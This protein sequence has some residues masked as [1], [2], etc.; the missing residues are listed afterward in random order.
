[1]PS[2][3][4]PTGHT[5]LWIFL[6]VFLLG[7]GGLI[8]SG[9]RSTVVHASR[10]SPTLL[11]KAALPATIPQKLEL[12]NTRGLLALNPVAV[13]VIDSL[14][15]NPA[16]RSGI[17]KITGTNFG[18]QETSQLLIDGKSSPF[19]ARWSDTL[20][21]AHVPEN[22]AIGN[23]TVSITTAVGTGS[24]TVAITTR[25]AD[26]RIRW[27]AEAA[28]DYISQRPAVA[29]PGVPGAGTVYAA[30]NAGLLYA[31]AADG[32]LKWVAPGASDDGPVSV[33]PDGTVYAA[34]G[35][36]DPGV[37]AFNPNG[38]QK[39]IFADANSQS[40][41]AGPNVGPDGKIYVILRPLNDQSVNLAAL[42]PDGTLA[43][44]VNRNFYRYGQLG[45]ELVFGRQLP[46]IYFSFDVDPDPGPTFTNGGFFVY[47]FD[48]QLVWEKGNICCGVPAVAPDE[49]IRYADARL[50]PLSGAIV[51]DFNFPPFGSTSTGVPD[52]GPDNTHYVEGGG[53]LWAI[54]PNGTQKWRYDP[55]LIN[56][57][58][59]SINSP[60]VNSTNTTIIMGGGGA[61]LQDSF[62]LGVNPAN[63]QELWRQFLPW[64]PAFQPYG[65][66]F[67]GDRAVFTQ[68]G[69][70][71]Y[72][73]GDQNGDQNLPFAE[74]YCFFYSLNTQTGVI[75]VNQPP[76]V[77][78]TSPLD[79]ANYPKNAQ[80]AISATAQDDQPI[81]KVEFYIEQGYQARVFLSE[82]ATAPYT[83]SFI[84]TQ[85]GGYGIIARV[86]DSGGLSAEQRIT[87][88]VS[89]ESPQVSW[90]SP[91]D[92]AV[93]D[94]APASITLTAH[95]SDA[96]GTI[97]NVEF[98]SNGLIGQDT[99]ADAQGNYSVTWTNP[100][101]GTNG[102]YAWATDNDGY[103][104]SAIITINVGP[105]PTPTPVPTPTPN[106]YT[107][108][109][110]TDGSDHEPGEQHNFPNRNQRNGS[111]RRSGSGRHH[112]AC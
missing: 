74:K 57:S 18:A 62:F 87:I 16:R 11:R 55:F 24:A 30:T 101:T 91:A 63:G 26:G 41:R 84:A 46:H 109:P 79:G 51:Y 71:A 69:N 90:V 70:T 111:R 59:A 2:E 96:D 25:T 110:A 105:A 7:L 37:I 75:P 27:R 81:N 98:W 29:P 44:S 38:T 107:H 49:G 97:A 92:G 61:Y 54:N 88:L 72:L 4:R 80:I 89:N 28:G 12:R 32:A 58:F 68:D 52:A 95:A 104:T 20:I 108:R 47:N 102:I 5:R 14:S 60:I 78:I 33:G 77:L 10:T 35:G 39:W 83:A 64:D 13:P 34:Y 94:P 67:L 3:P 66:Q 45:K 100:P 93:F 103:R 50:D 8:F 23:V 99:T 36:I 48:G 21:L 106:A 73:S 1:M 86:V 56:G 40:V 9:S 65:N 43:W 112:H 53:R 22:A 31:W 17:I 6:S 82:D 19:I 15:P 76:Q 42:R 85:A